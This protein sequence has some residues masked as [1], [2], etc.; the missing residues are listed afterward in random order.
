[1]CV[2][3]CVRVRVCVCVCVCVC[4]R[5]CVYACAL[6]F[7]RTSKGEK[8]TQDT[9]AGLAKI[10]HRGFRYTDGCRKR[11]GYGEDIFVNDINDTSARC[12]AIAQE[13]LRKIFLQTVPLIRSSMCACVFCVCSQVSLCMSFQCVY[14][15]FS[16]PHPSVIARNVL[17]LACMPSLF[18][19]DFS[20]C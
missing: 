4:A 10:P 11:L 15:S 20:V 16:Q 8:C 12:I 6:H 13:L 7:G 19:L 17:G 3:V 18:V 1:V 2:C 14:V 9:A 5:M